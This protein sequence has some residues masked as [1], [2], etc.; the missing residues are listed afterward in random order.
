MLLLGCMDIADMNTALLLGIL[1]PKMLCGSCPQPLSRAL[2]VHVGNFLDQ[3]LLA[4]PAACGSS[5]ARHQTLATAV[6]QA[7][8]LTH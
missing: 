7:R 8:S 5:R 1:M 2:K 4:A 3:F 6:T